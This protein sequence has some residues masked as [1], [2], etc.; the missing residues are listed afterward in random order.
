M[1]KTYISQSCNTIT[2]TLGHE[3][4]ENEYNDLGLYD[5]NEMDFLSETY[6]EDA[7]SFFSEDSEES[8]LDGDELEEPWIAMDEDEYEDQDLSEIYE[9]DCEGHDTDTDSDEEDYQLTDPRGDEHQ[10]PTTA[11][12]EASPP[13]EDNL[14]SNIPI[15]T[16]LPKS[17]PLPTPEPHHDTIALG[18]HHLWMM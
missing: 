5:S 17:N 11:S 1:Q 7:G 15:L 2:S 3:H 14:H 10:T 12:F 13:D 6:S 9:A 8:G 16:Q 4:Q 18:Q